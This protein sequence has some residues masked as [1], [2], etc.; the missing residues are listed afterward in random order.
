MKP[1]PHVDFYAKI[2][3]EQYRRTYLAFLWDKYSAA[4]AAVCE[5]YKTSLEKE[6]LTWVAHDLHKD[7][8]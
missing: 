6:N 8:S 2:I 5:K 4:F 7:Q 3:T 1:D